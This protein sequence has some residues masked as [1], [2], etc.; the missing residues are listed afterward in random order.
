MAVTVDQVQVSMGRTLTTAES[1]QATLWIS[2]ALVL[3]G[4][5][6]TREHTDISSVDQGVLDMVVREAV[7]ARIKKPDDATQV[8]VS[9][10]DGQMSRTY[11]SATGQIEIRDEWWEL[12]FPSG[13]GEAFSVPLSYR[14]PRRHHHDREPLSQPFWDVN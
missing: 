3:I 11:K 12:L 4:A 1:A 14:P 2:D 9:V 6:A 10:D 13:A 5:R 7:A 8:S